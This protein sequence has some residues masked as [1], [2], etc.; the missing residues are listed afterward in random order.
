MRYWRKKPRPSVR[1]MF[2]HLR[3]NRHPSNTNSS[4]IPTRFILRIALPVAIKIARLRNRWSN[5]NS[6]RRAKRVK[7]KVQMLASSASRPLRRRRE[8]RLKNLRAVHDAVPTLQ[9][10]TSVLSSATARVR[11]VTPG[12]QTPLLAA[13]IRVVSTISPG[14]RNRTWSLRLRSRSSL[15]FLNGTVLDKSLPTLANCALTMR[16][17]GS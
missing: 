17:S 15:A 2:L 10:Q 6:R 13:Q 11:R 16:N 5:K 8:Q 14:S 4:S 3:S 7:S 1:P 12:Q 9:R